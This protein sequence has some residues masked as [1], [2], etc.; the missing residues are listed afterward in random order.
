MKQDNRTFSRIPFNIRAE[1]EIMDEVMT[2]NTFQNLSVGGC[3]LPVQSAYQKGTPCRLTIKLSGESS[4]L[5]IRVSGTVLRSGRDGLAL[6]FTSIDPDSL[7]HLKNIVRYNVAD[8]DSVEQEFQEH[9]GL[10]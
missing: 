8:P 1:L 2:L 6:Q 4:D 10:F 3:L 9:P 7:F 5:Q